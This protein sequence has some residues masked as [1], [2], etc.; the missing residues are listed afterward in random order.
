[1][2]KLSAGLKALINSPAARPHTVPA[3][4]N[5]T[6][7]YQDIQQSAKANNVSQPS[8]L[9]LSTAATMTMNSP[10]IPRRPLHSLGLK[11]IS[12]NGIPRTINSLNAF[13]TS[14]PDPIAANLSKT[15][16]RTPTP[17]NISAIKDRGHALW[18]S[19]YR[20]FEKKLYNRLAD[21]HP[22]LPVIIL[23]SHYGALLSDPAERAASTS[24]SS[25]AGR[26]LTSIVAIACLRAQ[27]GVAPQVLSHVFGL[28]KALE[29]GS[30]ASDVESEQGARWLA[31]DEGNEWI[32]NSVDK[33]VKAIGRGQGSNFAPTAKL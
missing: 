18:D 29:D 26:V 28:R 6:A 11:C 13:K 15:P 22:D 30:W 17:E 21:S 1:M 27:S 5:I 25:S 32:L 19:I 7:I 33:I 9:A 31:S 20:P 2:S 24:A 14:L 23:N 12:F 16:T 8:W 3:P 10:R 4:K